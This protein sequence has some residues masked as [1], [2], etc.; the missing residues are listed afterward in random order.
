MLRI[1]SS[2]LSNQLVKLARCQVNLVPRFKFAG[3]ILVA[4]IPPG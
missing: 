1:G 3:A 2:L 4:R